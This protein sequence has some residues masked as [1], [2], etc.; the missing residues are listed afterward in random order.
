MKKQFTLIELLIVIAIIAILAG[1]LLPA[2]SATKDKVMLMSCTNNTKQITSAMLAYT[3]DYND[4]FAFYAGG[5]VY[6][7][8]DTAAAPYAKYFI[9][10]NMLSKGSMVCPA[11]AKYKNSVT[12]TSAHYF[13]NPRLAGFTRGSGSYQAAAA[14]GGVYAK[15]TYTLYSVKSAT[16]RH[17]STCPL[18]YRADDNNG[19]KNEVWTNQLVRACMEAGQSLK[20]L[21]C[22]NKFMSS[23]ISFSDGHCE[24]L[25]S[26]TPFITP[27][28]STT[29]TKELYGSG[30]DNWW[31]KGSKGSLIPGI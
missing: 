21:M 9:D 27:H 26:S 4:H 16:V 28:S 6:T 13:P 17:P 18:M 20:V 12:G 5:G 15:G 14:N 8:E 31:P 10:N 23:P 22:H 19:S 7:F 24:M 29:F 1:M 30:Q 3:N 25:N 11:N 2:L